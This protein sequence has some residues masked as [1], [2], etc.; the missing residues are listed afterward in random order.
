MIV[1]GSNS[2]LTAYRNDNNYDNKPM[3]QGKK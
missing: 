2:F 1:I 3:W